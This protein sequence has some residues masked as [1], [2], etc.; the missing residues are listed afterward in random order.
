MQKHIHDNH[1]PASLSQ[2]PDARESLTQLYSFSL[3]ICKHPV[4]HKF[5]LCQE[6][7]DQ[8]Y[9][10]PGGHV[11]P[12]E[13]LTFAAK[14]ETLEEAGVDV[15]L[16]GILAI[17]YNPCGA[18]KRGANYL[19]RMRV[20][21]YA[22]PTDQ[23]LLQLPKSIPDY[24]SVGASWCSYEDIQQR[25]PLRGSEPKKWSKYLYEGGIIYPL[26]LLAEREG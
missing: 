4:T 9:W 26:S 10:C 7:A 2:Y 22:E 11:D 14:R 1:K 25:L 17:E 15:E 23:G 24:E 21:F 13:T 16:K 5:L 6:F 20:I 8:G 12:G 3:V 18:H 19:V